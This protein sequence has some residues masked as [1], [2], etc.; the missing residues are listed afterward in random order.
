[1]KRRVCIV[2]IGMTPLKPLSEEVSYKEMMFEAAVKAYEDCGI[3]PRKDVDTFVCCS[4]DYIEGT[5]IFDEYVP[6]QIGGALKQVHTITSDGLFG[7]CAAILQLLTEEFKVAVV[8]AHAKAS[9]ILT[10]EGVHMCA[11]DPIYTRP[12]N[13]NPIF[14]AGLEYN[15]FLFNYPFTQTD[16]AEVVVKNKKNALKN[17]YAAYGANLS[18]EDV[19]NSFPVAYPLT[20][21]EVSPYADGACVIVLAREEVAKDLKKK[22][23]YIDGF[24]FIQ[25]SPNLEVRSW[26]YPRATEE[27]A[28][29]AYK[30]AG[31]S[32]PNKEI[33]FCEIDDTYSY[34]EIQNALALNCQDIIINPSGGSLGMGYIYEGTGLMRLI[35]AVLQLRGEAGSFQ[36]K[37]NNELPKKALVQSWRGLPTEN[38]CVL[39][40]NRE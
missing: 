31:I 24:S 1:M 33:D 2:G 26:E 16:C 11:L 37:I 32:N 4:E 35:M 17:P 6:D 7:V 34:K 19:L 30:M 23:I 15:S 14:I 40:L 9:N 21:L 8:E 20:E 28:K 13:V 39:I 12:L 36:I 10:P 25:G 22:P 27:A 18:V 5:S 29:R 38:S 3:N